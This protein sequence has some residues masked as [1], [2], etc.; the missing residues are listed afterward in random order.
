MIKC[1]FRPSFRLSSSPARFS[2]TADTASLGFPAF[3]KSHRF[4]RYP[5][6]NICVRLCT[7][8]LSLPQGRLKLHVIRSCFLMFFFSLSLSFRFKHFYLFILTL[9]RFPTT[10]FFY[11][12]LRYLFSFNT[13][14]LSF[15]LCFLSYFIFIFIYHFYKS[16]N[17]SNFCIHLVL[18]FHI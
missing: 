2:C 16:F 9:F 8:P 12:L 10:S 18:T 11:L 6:V 7:Q 15:S 3:Y 13:T 14:F 17:L 5:V 1:L 4:T